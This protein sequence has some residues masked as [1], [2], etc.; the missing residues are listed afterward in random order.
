MTTMVSKMAAVAFSL[1]LGFGMAYGA[2]GERCGSGNAPAP[3]EKCGHGKCGDAKPAPVEKCGHGK[4]G[5]SKPAPVEKC[6]HGK[7][8]D[9]K[10]PVPKSDM[11]CG[12][13]KCG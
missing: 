9:N 11:K 2:M 6:G 5:D 10:K 12:T 4:C 13:G 7:C 8:G 1:S 3:V